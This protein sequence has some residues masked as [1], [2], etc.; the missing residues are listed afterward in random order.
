MDCYSIKAALVKVEMDKE[1]VSGT[2]KVQK[3]PDIVIHREDIPF[4]VKRA[5]GFTS[6]LIMGIDEQT[7]T[8]DKVKYVEDA[9]DGIPYVENEEKKEEVK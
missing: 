2:G 4:V 3:I 1:A 6:G 5:Q 9:S 7:I 8:I